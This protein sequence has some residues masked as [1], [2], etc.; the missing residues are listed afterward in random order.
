MRLQGLHGFS[1]A[2]VAAQAS[3]SS[4][5]LFEESARNFD[6]VKLVFMSVRQYK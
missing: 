6:L 4:H 5:K 3:N 1:I 2:V